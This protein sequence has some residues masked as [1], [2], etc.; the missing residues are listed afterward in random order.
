MK[1][2]I[3]TITLLFI[4]VFT[5]VGQNGKMENLTIHATSLEGNLVE[6]ATDLSLGVYLPP[7]YDKESNKRYPV[8]YWLHGFSGWKNTT[9]KSGWN[10]DLITAVSKL[11]KSGAVEPMII[12]MPDGSNRFGG[13]FYT[14]SLTTGNW[15]D[16]I[17]EELPTYIDENYRTL[18]KPE[19]RGIAGHSMGG[20]GALKIAMKHPDVF[21]SVYGTCSCCITATPMDYGEKMIKYI[22]AIDSWDALRDSGFFPKAIHASAAAYAPNPNNPP[23]YSDLPYQTVGDS[24]VINEKAKA[25]WTANTVSWMASQ[26]ITNLKKLKG[27]AFD[28]ATDDNLTAGSQYFSD[29]LT[30]L[31]VKNS[32]E[33]F[34]GGH[35]DKV[36]ERIEDK[37]LPFFSEMLVSEK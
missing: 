2:I 18:A 27:I 12:V 23:F 26:Y 31:K 11:I 29:E 9:G 15:E 22:T 37:I 32:F 5:V 10:E 1:K 25:K 36:D 7:D 3:V 6:E 8:L 21:S 28:G 20:Y 24:I 30:R 17:V 14:N 16:F 19:S 35:A 13:S 33:I 4:S 34:E